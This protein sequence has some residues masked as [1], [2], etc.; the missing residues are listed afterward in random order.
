MDPDDFSIFPDFRKVP[1][2]KAATGGRPP[3]PVQQSMEKK[4]V[5]AEVRLWV[6]ADRGCLV[7]RFHP[8]RQ[9]H[10]ITES[11]DHGITG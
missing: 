9:I 8:H 3:A 1:A 2:G 11:R 10:G 5:N 7:Y 6:A 4:I